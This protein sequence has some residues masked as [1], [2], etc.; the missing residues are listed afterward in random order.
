MSKYLLSA[1]AGAAL[2]C[3]FATAGA[4]LVPAPLYLDVP[5][6]D[7]GTDNSIAESN[8]SRKLAVGAD[9]TI[10]AL[11]RSPTNGIRVARS[12]DGGQSFQSSVQVN[13]T[14][15]EA[16]IAIASDGD[17]HVA[18]STVTDVYHAVS[19]DGAQTFSTPVPVVTGSFVASAHMAVDGDRVYLIGR[20]GD[21]IFRSDDDGATFETIPTGTFAVFSDIFVD[22]LSHDVLVVTDDPNVHYYVS[23]DFGETFSAPIPTGQVVYY[24]VGA[25]SVTDSGR[26]L[27]FAGAFNNLER[28]AVD[29]QTYDGT[30]VNET[31]GSVTRSLS[32]DIFGNVVS[33][34]I[35]GV[36]GDL[37]FEHSNDL[38][39][40]FGTPVTVAQGA[41][42][43]NAAINN[44]NGD[45][46]FLY[47]KDGQIY[48]STYGQGLVGYDV[49]VSPTA[50]NF[51]SVEVGTES[52]LDVTLTNVASSAVTIASLSAA[53]DFSATDDCGGSIPASGECTVKVAFAPTAAGAAS[54]VL[55]MTLG[56][57][58]RQVSLMGT[59]T[60]AREP[61]TTALAASAANLAPGADVTLTATVTGTAPTGTVS[62]AQGGVALGGCAAVALTG[63]TAACI[64]SNLSAGAKQ[65]SATYDGDAGN[66]PST[67]ST[68]TVN[69]GEYTVT[70]AAG[71]GGSIDPADPQLVVVGDTA[72]FAVA[73]DSDYRVVSVAGCGGALAG[74]TFTTGAITA[75]CT[76]TATFE[77]TDEDVV[78]TGRSG[79]GGAADWLTV[80]IGLVIAFGRRALPILASVLMLGRAQAAE[81]GQWYVGGAFNRM[82][83]SQSGADVAADLARQ[84]FTPGAVSVGDLGRDGY[85]LFAGYRLSPNWAI[86][87]GHT[88]LGEV[89][90]SASA[91]VPAGQAEAYARALLE[92]LPASASGYE[93]SLNYRYPLSAGFALAARAGVWSWDGD[94]RVTFGNERLGASPHG[95][96]MLYGVGLEWSPARQWAVGLEATRYRVDDE[97]F[98]VLGANARFSW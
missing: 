74:S 95:T 23:T 49:N 20:N 32:A 98:D 19:G 69:V 3:V 14:D 5:V 7:I 36:T 66:Q 33:G 47:E 52:S 68:V 55:S 56:S 21:F 10:Y 84:G 77:P 80:L 17:L 73:A 83:G 50:L 28:I 30:V 65:Y 45:I 15:A 75:D 26:Y 1:L 59:G 62:F 92:A 4:Q 58:N 96:N 71:D 35:D 79:G 90:A 38:A 89:D 87:A 86:E 93:A 37:K 94:K 12:T 11:F 25:L 40:T 29:T 18:W 61:T 6:S 97:D 46:L 53:G 85:R 67:S 24:S 22:P 82:E 44:V 8:T 13:A 54:D 41:A 51:G 72:T 70:P 81:E 78:V 48:L 34:F 42:R 43:A 63:A 31:A 9:G 76:V 57:Q 16:E 60:P 64:V 27:F 88:D 39:A 2:S 91:T